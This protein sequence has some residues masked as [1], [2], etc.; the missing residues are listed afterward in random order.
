ML[1][2]LRS[3]YPGLCL[4]VPGVLCKLL[5]EHMNHEDSATLS[6][7][8]HISCWGY[9]DILGQSVKEGSGHRSIAFDGKFVYVTSSSLKCLLKV[10]TGKHG[11]IR[12]SGGGAVKPLKQGHPS[13]NSQLH[14]AMYIHVTHLFNRD[15]SSGEACTYTCNTLCI[16][17]SSL[18]GSITGIHVPFVLSQRLCVL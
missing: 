5:Q 16:G 10:G 13:K 1:Q 15:A 4:L 14:Y 2:S 11:T 18:I 6:A 3:S 9:E 7:D 8:T 17:D 12:Y